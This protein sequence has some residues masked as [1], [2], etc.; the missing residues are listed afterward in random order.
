M[1]GLLLHRS[2]RKKEKA[3]KTK[4]KEKPWKAIIPVSQVYG[5]LLF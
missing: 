1:E 4:G 2:K 5:H 3:R